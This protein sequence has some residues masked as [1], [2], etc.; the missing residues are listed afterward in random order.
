[1]PRQQLPD[2]VRV[3]LIDDTEPRYRSGAVA[4]MARMPVATLRTWERRF[5]VV[6][7][8][9]AP[10]G[11][12][13]YSAADVKRLT[14]LK[15]LSDIGHSIGLMS[16]LDIEKLLE[17]A[18]THATIQTLALPRPGFDV[19]AIAPPWRVVVVGPAIAGRL[20]R[21]SVLRRLGRQLELIG[22]F[23][24]VA[25]CLAFARGRLPDAASSK[26]HPEPSGSRGE[27][28]LLLLDLPTLREDQAAE[29]Q[30]LAG[31]W[32]TEQAALLC[33]YAMPSACD[34]ASRAGFAVQRGPMSDETLAD[35][36]RALSDQSAATQ[37]SKAMEQSSLPDP[38]WALPGL[39]PPRRFDDTTLADIA[40][41]SSTVACECP[42]HVSE[43][44]IQLS[45]FEAYSVECASQSTGEAELH[46][47]LQRAAASARAVLESALERIALH[48]GLVLKT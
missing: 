5:Q 13:L 8:T 28:G 9:A 35:W 6:A 7:P 20:Q 46:R 47:F 26:P 33:G 21:T 12:R 19:Q 41:L 25:E 1:M 27:H 15:Q 30:Q 11:H 22:P 36:L 29:L 10:S 18:A 39:A 48:E 4:R 44:L 31:A 34:A 2:P 40:A 14:L 43:L 16:K 3:R 17:V 45:A 37:A 32:R 23:G 42:R 24:S 38:S